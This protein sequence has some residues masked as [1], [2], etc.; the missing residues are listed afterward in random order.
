MCLFQANVC[1]ERGDTGAARK[2]RDAAETCSRP[3]DDRSV[4]RGYAVAR[5]IVESLTESS[6]Y[7]DEEGEDTAAL[8][9]FLDHVGPPVK[10]HS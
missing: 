6:V 5:E 3:T 8:M 9:A 7:I 4:R 10:P 1:E 2:W